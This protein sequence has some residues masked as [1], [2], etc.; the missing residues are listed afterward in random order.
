MI[1]SVFKGNT[2]R[3]CKGERGNY[4]VGSNRSLGGGW[5]ANYYPG[6]NCTAP[7]VIWGELQRIAI[8]SGVPAE[9]FRSPEP[10]EKKRSPRKK[11]ESKPSISIF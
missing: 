6:N 11:K 3:F 1:E 8:A 2:Y 5:G 4:W 10:E 7:M 9:A